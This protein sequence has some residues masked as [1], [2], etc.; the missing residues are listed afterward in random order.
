MN[1]LREYE[2]LRPCAASRSPAASAIS[3]SS[4]A[5]SIRANRTV[6]F[7]RKRH[8]GGLSGPGRLGH[9]AC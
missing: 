5:A 8:G 4:G 1:T 6:F 7:G 2:T 9:M 3:A